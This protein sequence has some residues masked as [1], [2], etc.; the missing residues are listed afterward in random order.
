MVTYVTYVSLRRRGH[1]ASQESRRLDV[2]P[3]RRRAR[4]AIRRGCALYSAHPLR[5]SVRQGTCPASGLLLRRKDVPTWNLDRAAGSHDTRIAYI[6]ADRA[7]ARTG[8]RSHAVDVWSAVPAATWRI[9]RALPACRFA[10][11]AP[12]CLRCPRDDYIRSVGGRQS[13]E[14]PRG[15]EN[16]QVGRW[17]W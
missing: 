9:H 11:S 2:L 12:S 17:A 8:L 13:P 10:L 14:S 7:S 4:R 6:Q 5:C 16:G 3:A 1:Q 15:I